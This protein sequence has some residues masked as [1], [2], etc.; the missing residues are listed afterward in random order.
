MSSMQFRRNSARHLLMFSS[1]TLPSADKP[2]AHQVDLQ[3]DNTT[4]Y[5]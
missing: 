4:P 5:S 2:G 1:F 3:Q